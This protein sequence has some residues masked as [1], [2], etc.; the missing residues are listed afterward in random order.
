MEIDMTWRIDQVEFICV[1]IAGIIHDNGTCFDR[2]STSPL[3]LHV[4]QQL[5]LHFSLRNGPRVFEQAVGQS[6]FAVVDVGDNTEV[7]DQMAAGR[8][9]GVGNV[10]N[11]SQ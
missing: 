11:A 6:A 9:H 3:E 10:A 7:A 2:N 5:L 8:W 1:A 4:V